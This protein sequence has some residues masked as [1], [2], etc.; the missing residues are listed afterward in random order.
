MRAGTRSGR[1]SSSCWAAKNGPKPSVF[2]DG[3]PDGSD[4]SERS[5]GCKVVLLP[6][7][8]GSKPATSGGAALQPIPIQGLART[9]ARGDDERAMSGRDSHH[10]S[11]AVG[12]LTWQP[13]SVKLTP[14]AL[15]G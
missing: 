7:G 15:P 2:K 9:A 10:A 14:P 5:N 3:L 4:E 8:R 6:R 11:S 13:G 1:P 12:T